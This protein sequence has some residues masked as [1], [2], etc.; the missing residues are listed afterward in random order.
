[1]RIRKHPEGSDAWEL[2]AGRTGLWY[3]AVCEVNC[4]V[5]SSDVF[6][7]VLPHVCLVYSHDLAG[8]ELLLSFS[9]EEVDKEV[10]SA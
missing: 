9:E 8:K 10:Q 2:R 7:S 1:M 3:D 6:L 5:G 4:D